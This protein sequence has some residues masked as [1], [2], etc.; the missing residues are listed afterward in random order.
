MQQRQLKS[1][2]PK[3]FQLSEAGDRGWFVGSFERAVFQTN[4]LEAGYQVNL[5]GETSKPHFHKIATEINLIVRGAVLINGELYTAGMGVI[6]YPTE[7]AEC[8]YIEDTETMVIKTPGALN[9]KYLI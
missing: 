7:V 8:V 4:D 2:M 1:K 6:F 3:Q 5:K 9:D